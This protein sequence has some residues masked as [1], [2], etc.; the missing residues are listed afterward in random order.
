M[1]KGNH[2]QRGKFKYKSLPSE[3]YFSTQRLFVFD[4]RYKIL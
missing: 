2:K 3:Q 4:V 1:K